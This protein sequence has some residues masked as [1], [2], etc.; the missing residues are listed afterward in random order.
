MHY[1]FVWQNWRF[2]DAD[3]SLLTFLR[4]NPRLDHSY[5]KLYFSWLSKVSP[6]LDVILQIFLFF[7]QHFFCL[8]IEG[9]I[10][11]LYYV[12]N[13]I[14]VF[15]NTINILPYLVFSIAVKQPLGSHLAPLPTPFPPPPITLNSLY[16]T[17]H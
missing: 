14:P 15:L 5:Y 1:T 7:K 3:Q 8:F 6:Y 11:L 16:L 10:I 17:I 2:F 12:V 13:L 4:W 9:G